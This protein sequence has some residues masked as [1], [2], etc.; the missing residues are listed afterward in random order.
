MPGL[1]PDWMSPVSQ[2]LIKKIN[3]NYQNLDQLQVQQE[4][5]KLV[6]ESYQIN[7]VECINVNPATNLLNPRAEK[8]LSKGMSSRPSLGHP[9]DKYETGLEAIEQIEII[10]S[11]LAN[12]VFES[13]YAEFRVGSGSL[14]NLYAFMSTCEPHDVIIAP[15]ATIGGHITHHLQGAAG[16]YKLKTIPAPVNADGYTVD[17]EKLKQLALEVKPK[18]I[19]IGGSLNLFFHPI[20]EIK[21]IAN[22]V[23][24]KVLFDAAHLCGMIAGKVWPQPLKEGA[25]LMTFSTYKSLGGPAGGLIVTNNK[26]I[27]KKLDAI[28]YPGL[29]ANFDAAKTAALAIT[30]QDW[31]SVGKNYAQK[32]AS[33]AKE[34]ANALDNKGLNLF[35]K[36]KGFTQSHQFAVIANEFGG[37]QTASKRLRKANILACGI[38]LPGETVENDV[39]GLRIGTPELVRIGM[40]EKDMPQLADF[41]YRAL[42]TDDLEKIAKEVTEFRSQFKGVHYT[43][44]LP[45]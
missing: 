3:S 4:I 36:N 12:D 28:A 11:A 27:A 38:G 10:T 16:L 41:I 13:E 20:K 7:D 24:A 19:T 22:L 43:L 23:N 45:E 25:D 15:P 14:A 1:V 35:A 8:L 26:E 2:E 34:L 18:L 30:L 21:E 40:K 5:E 29:T 37:G 44:D 33:C 6:D 9:G 42:T 32:M 39:N 31:K 17:V